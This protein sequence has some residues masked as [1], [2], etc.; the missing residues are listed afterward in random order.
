MEDVYLELLCEGTTEKKL[1][2]IYR[3][4][5]MSQKV[6]PGGLPKKVAFLV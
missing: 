3:Q 6:T 2:T 4:L 1:Y 5:I